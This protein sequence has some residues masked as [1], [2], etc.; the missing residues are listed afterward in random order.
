MSEADDGAAVARAIFDAGVVAA[1]PAAA[2]RASLTAAPVQAERIVA[3]GKAALA[4]L[5]AAR[6]RLPDVPALAVTNRENA[7]ETAG[8][9]VLV[10]GHPV[11]DVAGEVAARAVEAFVADAGEDETVL[12]LVSG[13]A[14]A[15]LPAPVEGVS[16]AEK[17]AVTELLLG[18]GVPI[19]E[20]NAVRRALSRLKGGGLARAIHPA[21]TVA[22]LLSDVPR[23]EIAAIG[24]GPTVAQGTTA[25]ASRA[26]IDVLRRYGLAERVPASVCKALTTRAQ[27]DELDSGNEGGAI[28]ENRLVGGNGPSLDAMAARCVADGLP[29]RIVT[30]WLDGDVADAAAAMHRAAM[31]APDGKFALL[32]G[33]ETT[34]VLR[35]D[36]VGGRNQELALRFAML[37]ERT[38]LGRS[39]AFLSGGT[40]GRDGPTEAAG[41]LVDAATVPAIRAAGIDPTEALGRNDSG[42]AL[43]AGGGLL[44]TGPTGT[45]VADLQVLVLGPRDITAP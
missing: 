24:S 40:D 22:L 25:Q 41:G 13:G 42:T 4:M 33:G 12:V 26:A 45:N 37:A 21:R 27:A 3:V 36:G 7:T 43:A 1:D 11:S 39:W 30:R 2:V 10:A 19:D 35:G 32:V 44:V 23:D 29:H 18:S 28:V 8:A 6:E 9:R 38:P 5:A 31:D 17:I 16:L 14:S 15:M 34:V 20:M